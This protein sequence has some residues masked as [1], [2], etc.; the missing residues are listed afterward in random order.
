MIISSTILS[1]IA[2]TRESQFIPSIETV[3]EFLVKTLRTIRPEG[4]NSETSSVGKEIVHLIKVLLDEFSFERVILK[5][6][7]LPE[8]IACLT[9]A[10]ARKCCLVQI[11]PKLSNFIGEEAEE[12]MRLFGCL[13]KT[14]LVQLSD[15]IYDIETL[16]LVTSDLSEF[17]EALLARINKDN[18]DIRAV[19]DALNS[20]SSCLN[21]FILPK[22]LSM[23]AY[24]ESFYKELTGSML[25]NTSTVLPQRLEEST[26]ELG[27]IEPEFTKLM[28]V[29]MNLEVI[30]RM[31]EQSLD[32]YEFYTEVHIE[33]L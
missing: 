10:S 23:S 24:D 22:L 20:P 8:L 25:Q 15:N 32:P 28:A 18:S 4:F 6:E 12:V 13:S 16:K 26:D 30:D 5:I 29:K 27:W 14:D 7:A 9:P 3:L 17:S 19:F 1:L 21:L 11:L 2:K 31:T 33:R